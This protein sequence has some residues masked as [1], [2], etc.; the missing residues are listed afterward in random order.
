MLNLVGQ[1]NNFSGGDKIKFTALKVN[2]TLLKLLSCGRGRKSPQNSSGNYC[3]SHSLLC[4]TLLLVSRDQMCRFSSCAQKFCR[5]YRNR[6]LSQ[7]EF[8]TSV[9]LEF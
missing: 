5:S 6:N 8:W 3:S 2:S 4:E 9:L 7:Q 1:L